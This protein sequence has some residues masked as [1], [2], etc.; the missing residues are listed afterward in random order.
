MEIEEKLN[1]FLDVPANFGFFIFTII[2]DS[3]TDK[4]RLMSFTS[5]F[6]ELV[7]LGCNMVICYPVM[8]AIKYGASCSCLHAPSSPF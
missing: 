4:N 1:C 5:A 3:V 6:N 7:I 8:E 2:V